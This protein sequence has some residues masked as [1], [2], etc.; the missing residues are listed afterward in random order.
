[1]RAP[2]PDAPAQTSAR[3]ANPN[4]D[5]TVREVV[6]TPEEDTEVYA[7]V[8]V[9]GKPAGQTESGRRSQEK[10]WAAELEEGNRLMRFEVWDSSVTALRWPE[11]RQPR[12]RFIRVEQG[13]KTKVELRF[14][15]QGRQYE[16]GISQEH[17]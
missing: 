16:L 10:R 2:S 13:K 12:E 3:A 11:D 7:E 1:M 17:K 4:F 15:D 8:F 14:F 5:L 9:D 6:A